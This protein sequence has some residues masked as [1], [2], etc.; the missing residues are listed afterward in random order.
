MKIGYFKSYIIKFY[1]IIVSYIC[2]TDVL[3]TWGI[4][5]YAE[6]YHCKKTNEKN[7][8]IKIPVLLCALILAVESTFLR[9]QLI[10]TTQ[11]SLR[12]IST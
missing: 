4:S 12:Q 5:N 3:Q 1:S 11:I 7:N 6:K 2:N 8:K 9:K 10:S